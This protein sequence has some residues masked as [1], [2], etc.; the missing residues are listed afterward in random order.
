ML[1]SIEVLVLIVVLRGGEGRAGWWLGR[2]QQGNVQ[3]VA[4]LVEP[5]LDGGVSDDERRRDE[6]VEGRQLGGG[7]DEQALAHHGRDGVVGR[8]VDRDGGQ[9]HQRDEAVARRRRDRRPGEGVARRVQRRQH[10]QQ[11]QQDA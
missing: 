3:S 9:E 10:D 2:V 1:S 8:R 6:G 11:R 5:G 7:R 4:V